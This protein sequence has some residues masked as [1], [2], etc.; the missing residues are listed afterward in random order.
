METTIFF[1][2]LRDVP[3]AGCLSAAEEP[4][5]LDVGIGEGLP[6]PAWMTQEVKSLLEMSDPKLRSPL[7]M[8]NKIIMTRI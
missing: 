1:S 6:S 8:H 4:P 3:L 5:A 2:Q 7:W